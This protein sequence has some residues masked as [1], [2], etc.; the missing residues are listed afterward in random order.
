MRRGRGQKQQHIVASKL[1]QEN[2]VSDGDSDGSQ[3]MFGVLE[4]EGVLGGL[5]VGVVVGG[6]HQHRP[7]A[8]A[9]PRFL[10]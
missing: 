5:W 2:R 1:D 8:E 4:E 3:R 6:C 9:S 7:P 10:L